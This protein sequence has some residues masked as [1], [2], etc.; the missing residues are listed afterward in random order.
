MSEMGKK[1]QAA[2]AARRIA[3]IDLE[4]LADELANPMPIYG[5]AVGSIEIR[6][7]GSGTVTRWTVLRGTRRNNY[8][9]RSPDGRKSRDHGMAW[10]LDHIRPVLLSRLLVLCLLTS[11]L[12]PLS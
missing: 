6:S 7:F 5:D 3:E 1:S 4:Q 9:R 12:L 2:R 10:I 11:P 8:M